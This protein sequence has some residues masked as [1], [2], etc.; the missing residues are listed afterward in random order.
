MLTPKNRM[1]VTKKNERVKRKDEQNTTK[2]VR[3]A[4]RSLDREEN[5][6]KN[7]GG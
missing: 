1:I 4:E 6:S 2:A 5:V 7:I 3:R